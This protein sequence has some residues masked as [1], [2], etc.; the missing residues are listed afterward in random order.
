[1]DAKLMKFLDTIYLDSR[2]S[3]DVEVSIDVLRALMNKLLKLRQDATDAYRT[4][5]AKL[6]RDMC[7]ISCTSP[8]LGLPACDYSSINSKL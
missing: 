2:Y 3:D 8:N 5:T 7:N 1:M 6:M 4:E